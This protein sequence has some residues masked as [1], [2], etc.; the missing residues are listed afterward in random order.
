MP[1][2]RFLFWNAA[3]GIVWATVVGLIA[4]YGGKAVADAIA[5]YGLYAGIVIVVALVV[6]WLGLRFV[7]QRVERRL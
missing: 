7:R 6:G 5:R 3:G 4:Y 2:W 1:W